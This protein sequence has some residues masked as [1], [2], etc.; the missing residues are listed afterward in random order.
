MKLPAYMKITPDAKATV[1]RVRIKWWGWPVIA[2]GIAKE[3]S[4]P[5][6]K[7]PFFLLVGTIL[8]WKKLLGER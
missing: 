4:L 7:K 2:Y 3:S 1:Y 5:F 6:Y 8:I